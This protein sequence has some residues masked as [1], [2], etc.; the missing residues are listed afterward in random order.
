MGFGGIGLLLK[1]TK[2]EGDSK[3]NSPKI[4]FRTIPTFVFGLV[5]KYTTF[6]GLAVPQA[7]KPRVSTL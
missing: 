3:E 7:H 1:G 2:C 6:G 4:D 5:L